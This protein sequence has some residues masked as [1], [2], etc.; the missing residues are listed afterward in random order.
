MKKRIFRA[1]AVLLC[2]LMCLQIVLGAG[3]FAVSVSA[4]SFDVPTK[5]GQTVVLGQTHTKTMAHGNTIYGYTYVSSS[6]F[7]SYINAMPSTYTPL[8]NKTVGSVQTY[9]Y[10]HASGVAHVVY[11]GGERTMYLVLDDRSVTDSF[12]ARSTYTKVTDVILAPLSLDAAYRPLTDANGMGQVFILEDG[13][14]LIL[15]GGYTY[16]GERLYN[17]LCDNNKRTDGEIVIHAWYLSHGHGD[18]IGAIDYI[19]KNHNSDVTVENIIAYAGSSDDWLTKYTETVADR[20]GRNTKIV[21]PRTGETYQMP[22]LTMDILYTGDDLYMATQVNN[23]GNE[24]ST[25]CRIT[26]GEQT[27]LYTADLAGDGTTTFTDMYGSEVNSTF[28]QVNHHGISG[29]TTTLYNLLD[30]DYLIFTSSQAATELRTS[31]DY[32]WMDTNL[33]SAQ[34]ALVTAVGGYDNVFAADG[35]IELIPLPYDG[36]RDALEVYVP[37]DTVRA[38]AAD[39]LFEVDFSQYPDGTYTASQFKSLTG[40]S[41]TNTSVTQA[42]IK[43]ENG[44]LRL[45]TS[46]QDP[47]TAFD[48]NTGEGT[49]KLNGESELVFSSNMEHFLDGRTV[50]EYEMTYNESIIPAEFG[51][52]MRVANTNISGNYWLEITPFANGKITNRY[53]YNNDWQYLGPDT[54]ATSIPYSR[55]TTDYATNESFAYPGYLMTD[56]Y[57]NFK[58]ND[59]DGVYET[60]TLTKQNNTIFGSTDVYK[61][62]IDPQNGVDVY[63]NGT[64]VSS[65]RLPDTWDETIYDSIIGTEFLMRLMPGMDVTLGN[66]KIYREDN[67]PELVIT[68]IAPRVDD[69]A[70]MGYLEVYNNS[71]G[72]INI[73]DYQI[74]RD[75]LASKDGVLNE[76]YFYQILPGATIWTSKVNAAN[77]VTHT[78]SVYADG[79]L[80]AG[81]CALLW[82]PYDTMHNTA[83]TMAGNGNT[84]S[85]FRTAVGV[86]DSVKVFVAYNRYNTGLATSGSHLYAI[87]S[88]DVNYAGMSDVLYGNFESYVY[89]TST[90]I[91]YTASGNQKFSQT[92]PETKAPDGNSSVRY[93]YSAN[94]QS[95]KGSLY[96]AQ[97]WVM[98]P[99]V[100]ETAQQR[101]SY[102]TVRLNGAEKT[103]PATLDL[104]PYL[105][106]PNAEKVVKMTAADG[107]VS[108]T[109]STVICV[110]E[111]M[112][113]N[114]YE[115]AD[116][117]LYLFREDFSGYDAVSYKEQDVEVTTDGDGVETYTTKSYSHDVTLK[118]LFGWKHIVGT[119]GVEFEITADGAFRVYNPYYAVSQRDAD[120]SYQTPNY[121]VQVEIGSFSAMPDRT[122]VLEYDFTYGNR[123]D[124]ASTSGASFT[125]GRFIDRDRYCFTPAI[126]AG[127]VYRAQVGTGSSVTPMATAN[128]ALSGG[129][130]HVKVVID[131][132]AGMT[133]SVN[134]TV[135]S[136]VSGNDWTALYDNMGEMLGL[137]IAGGTEVTFDNIELYEMDLAKAADVAEE[138]HKMSLTTLNGASIR[139]SVP[140]GMRWVTAVE[141]TDYELVQAWLAG[142][143]ITDVE[144]GTILIRT[145]DLGGDALTLERANGV[146]CFALATETWYEEAPA[147]CGGYDASLVGTHLFAG[148]VANIRVENYNVK[149]SAVGYLSITLADGRVETI[150]GDYDAANHSRTVAEVARSAYDDPNSGLSAAERQVVKVFA[151]AYV[152]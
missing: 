108:Q 24:M 122:V 96:A 117:K 139:T 53:R 93:C 39:T 83:A 92:V 127:G 15:D 100:I 102:V 33:V 47:N 116:E 7:T 120:G 55:L 43:I 8:W 144:M 110:S 98:T 107:T 16:D 131:P 99:G 38:K 104:T 141:S 20:F 4:A 114:I 6:N 150:Y 147:V 62:V 89:Y 23:A 40:L 94:N 143:L 119:D 56:K 27:L 64:L 37:D 124:V 79:W 77:T 112:T 140:T 109:S 46:V 41:V 5:P 138:F 30:P 17:F 71:L 134:G 54:V 87:G 1:S 31:V 72:R 36:N 44:K 22:G 121:D 51:A 115:G 13:S 68:E 125:F 50:I 88:A 11:N 113:I 73:Y 103:V 84:V 101:V 32:Q 80:E 146:D 45:S 42:T 82:V 130:N 67:A 57:G 91:T 106:A 12:A 9:A 148:S 61:L 97:L 21:R 149:Y 133:V 66:V 29:G 26:V 136:T 95:R 90:P 3:L 69:D 49:P 19:S 2:F 132:V 34:K 129:T 76:T 86:A 60:N 58:D 48:I 10:S 142:G 81:E 118:N 105:S 152:G 52:P 35:V 63:V 59:E 75:A 137:S 111:G 14:Y 85:S 70:S 123:G 151:D 128:V 25:V 18:H 65:T 28:F 78:N 135:I 145:A 126:T 74:L